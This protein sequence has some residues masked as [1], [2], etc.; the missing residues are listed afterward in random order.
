MVFRIFQGTVGWIP[1]IPEKVSKD[2]FFN[3]TLC[4][5]KGGRVVFD[6]FKKSGLG[7]GLPELG[8]Y[9]SRYSFLWRMEALFLK[10]VF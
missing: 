4:L 1:K 9:N 8:L 3:F 5:Y 6:F 2:I 10:L 7:S